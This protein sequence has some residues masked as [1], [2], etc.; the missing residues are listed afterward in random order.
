MEEKKLLTCLSCGHTW[1][2][3]S[4]FKKITCPSCR[5]Y[6]INPNFKFIKNE[7]EK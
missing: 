4:K 2:S 1:N 5:G 7:N 6:V 3:K